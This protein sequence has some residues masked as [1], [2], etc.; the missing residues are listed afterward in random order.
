LVDA[1]DQCRHQRVDRDVASTDGCTY[2]QLFSMTAFALF[3]LPFG[4]SRYSVIPKIR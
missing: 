2:Q 3:N 4:G 1:D